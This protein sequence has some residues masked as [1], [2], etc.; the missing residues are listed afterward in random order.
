MRRGS[1]EARNESRHP[2]MREVENIIEQVALVK[3]GF[4]PIR[5]LA[6]ECLARQSEDESLALAHALYQSDVHQARM[7]ATILFGRFAPARS[8]AFAFLRDVVSHDP[9]WR[10]QEMLAMAFD[11]YCKG[12]GYEQALPVIESWLGDANPNVRRAAS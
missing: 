2:I 4:K 7:M 1:G 10:T 9:D 3:D 5:D 8:E 6:D 12:V 11:S